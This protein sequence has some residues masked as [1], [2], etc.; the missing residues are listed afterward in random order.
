MVT[1]TCPVPHRRA[2]SGCVGAV[3]ENV[4]VALT[5]S[6]TRHPHRPRGT[7]HRGGAAAG[8]A[9]APVDQE[10]LGGGG[11]TLPSGALFEPDVLLPTFGAFVAFCLAASGTLPHQRQRGMWRPT[12]ATPPSA[13]VRSPRVR[14][15][16]VAII[17]AVV[18]FLAGIGLGTAISLGL[19]AV[20]AAYVLVTLAYSLRPGHGA[21]HRVGVRVVG[22]LAARDRRRVAT[23]SQSRVW[24][25]IVAGFG[26]LFM[27][28]GKRASELNLVAEKDPAERK[29]T[30]KV[31]AGYTPTY[32]R[33]VWGLAATVTVTAYCLWAFEVAAVH[34]R[35]GP[36]SASSPSSWRSCA[37]PSISTRTTPGRPTRWC[38]PTGS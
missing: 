26:S 4:A 36:R 15:P 22:L 31:L 6:Q 3:R 23:G 21:R 34:T 12:A 11:P 9:A 37:T 18:L 1:S 33:F 8:D 10:R 27:A 24:F 35:R 17:A 29:N 14:S 13:T 20:V 5:T 16:R 19:G 25:L 32:L 38:C 28:A 30:R 7:E 2:L